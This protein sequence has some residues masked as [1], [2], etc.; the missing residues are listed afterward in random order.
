MP[1]RPRQENQSKNQRCDQQG[2]QKKCG[3]HEFS[4][5]LHFQSYAFHGNNLHVR[6]NFARSISRVRKFRAPLFRTDFYDAAITLANPL[7]NYS[8]F[9]N[10]RINVRRLI[11]YI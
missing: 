6:A 5:S 4:S 11:L 2:R 10:H 3:I 9:S 7:R 1:R 8:R